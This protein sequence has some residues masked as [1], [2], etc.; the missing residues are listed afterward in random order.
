MNTIKLNKYLINI[1]EEY[2]TVDIQKLITENYECQDSNSYFINKNLTIYDIITKAIHRGQKGFYINKEYHYLLEDSFIYE[3]I[4]IYNN[5]EDY[6]YWFEKDKRKL[7][8]I[9]IFDLYNVIV[10]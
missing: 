6:F 3:D 5:Q 10:W 2:N 9:D 1:I 4:E 8:F 7:P